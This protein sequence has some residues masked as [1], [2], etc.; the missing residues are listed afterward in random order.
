MHPLVKRSVGFVSFDLIESMVRRGDFEGSYFIELQMY[1]EALLHPGFGKI[2]SYLKSSSGVKL[3]MS[4][5]G[6]LIYKN[7]D[8]ISELDFLTISVDSANKGRYE[9]LRLG[10]SF[11]KLIHGIEE[12]LNRDPRPVIDLQVIEF[13]GK[14]K[15]LSTLTE[16]SQRR[17]WDVTC[18]SVPDC[19]AAYQDRPYPK[20]NLQELCL[21]PWLSVSIHWDG[22]VVPCCFSA[23]KYIVYGNLSKMSMADIWDKNPVRD[24]LRDRMRSN[25]NISNMPCSKCYMRSPAL[26]H[27]KMLMQNIRILGGSSE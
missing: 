7:L 10:S 1:G 18:R 4:T 14:D 24:A 17:Q 11:D 3:G 26:L 27:L 20:R 9:S 15:E 12:L 25:Y 23:G 13:Y 2:V 19:F 8:S 16:L 21:N 5:N 6:T 22:D